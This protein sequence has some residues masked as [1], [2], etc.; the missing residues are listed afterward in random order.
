MV[1]SCDVASRANAWCYCQ[2]PPGLVRCLSGNQPLAAGQRPICGGVPTHAT[3]N[4]PA[5]GH[6]IALGGRHVGM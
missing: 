4:M 6:G 3:G 1:S 5:A 2:L